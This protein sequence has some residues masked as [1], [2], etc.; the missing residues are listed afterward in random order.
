MSEFDSRVDLSIGVERQELRR[1]RSEIEDHLSD[2]AIGLDAPEGGRGARADGGDGRERRRR[3]REFRW[4]RQRT[5]DLEE[6]VE[7]LDDIEDN[8]GEGGDG[9][10]GSLISGAGGLGAGVGAG[11]GAA[12]GSVAGE[13]ISGALADETVSVEDPDWRPIGVEVPDEA[14]DVDHP[15]EPYAVDHPEEPYPVEDVDPIGVE[16]PEWL[17]GVQRPEWDILVERPG[18]NIPVNFPQWAPLPVEQPDPIEVQVTARGGGGRPVAPP[19]QRTPGNG[20][21]DRSL[22][23]RGVRALPIVGPVA[24]EFEG[25]GGP[26]QTPGRETPRSS[27]VDEPVDVPSELPSPGEARGA[28][29]EVQTVQ[30]EQR[31]T[32]DIGTIDIDVGTDEIIDETVDSFEAEIARV[33]QELQNRIDELEDRIDQALR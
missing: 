13:L 18:W 2:I 4:A 33:E 28:G 1:V 15:E 12:V 31:V 11:I 10:L 27:I 25:A 16:R 14:V 3:R 17:V 32:T 30:V 22:F 19:A 29:V 23:E 6:A 5:D 26:P 24:R 8:I 20:D 9:L 7:L 21:R